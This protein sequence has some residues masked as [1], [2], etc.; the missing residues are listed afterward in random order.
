MEFNSSIQ[1]EYVRF[2]EKY[3]IGLIKRI[4]GWPIVITK[5]EK[6]KW[7]SII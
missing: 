4:V 7:F 2:K 5:Q 6:N 3:G 1:E